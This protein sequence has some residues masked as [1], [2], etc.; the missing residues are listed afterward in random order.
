[1]VLAGPVYAD[2]YISLK[3]RIKD[4]IKQSTAK[5]DVTTALLRY[6]A[7]TNM[8]FGAQLYDSE[9][10]SVVSLLDGVNTS[11]IQVFG[12][13]T[14]YSLQG[15]LSGLPSSYN[16]TSLLCSPYEIPRLITEN[17]V[18]TFEGGINDLS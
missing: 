5:T 14:T 18:L 1:V 3:V 10:L 8:P 11:S 12:R 16:S 7:P 6:F 15:T 4:G 17:L 13:A 9:V 2:I